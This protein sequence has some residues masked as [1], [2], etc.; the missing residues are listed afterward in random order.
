[1]PYTSPNPEA[2]SSASEI[3]RVS[4]LYPGETVV[5]VNAA[6]EAVIE[7]IDTIITPFR[8][9]AATKVPMLQHLLNELTRGA[10][11]WQAC[12]ELEEMDSQ[13]RS[14]TLQDDT[15][16]QDWVIALAGATLFVSIE[17]GSGIVI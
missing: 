8:T 17:G 15:L 2:L 11:L 1:M 5:E 6:G 4:R 12:E 13:L 14:Y 16:A 7:S 10:I 3:V 9:T